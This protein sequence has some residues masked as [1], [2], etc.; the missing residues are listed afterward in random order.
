[1]ALSS[2]GAKK[3]SFG[4]PITHIS[5]KDSPPACPALCRDRQGSL[6]EFVGS[7]RNPVNELMIKLKKGFV[8]QNLAILLL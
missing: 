1:M 2:K 8:K 7:F 4:S 6:Q 3:N 5:K